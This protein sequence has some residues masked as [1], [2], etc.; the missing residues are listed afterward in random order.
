MRLK[1]CL[2]ED[3]DWLLAGMHVDAR[4]G[5]SPKSTSCR[6]PFFP[7]MIACVIAASFRFARAK[8]YASPARWFLAVSCCDRPLRPRRYLAAC[9]AKV[10]PLQRIG[11]LINASPGW[12]QP[13][14]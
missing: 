11:H 1:V 5:V 13:L 14:R 3:L 12:R 10:A 6:R 9:L 7:R 2:A 4:T 8:T